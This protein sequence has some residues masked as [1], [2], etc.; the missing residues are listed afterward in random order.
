MS[1]SNCDFWRVRS[2]QFSHT[3]TGSEEDQAVFSMMQAR[4]LIYL[5]LCPAN[6]LIA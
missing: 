4:A 5:R 2:A 1:G 6:T 3:V